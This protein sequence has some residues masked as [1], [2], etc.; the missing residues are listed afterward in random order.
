[1]EIQ[2]LRQK[3]H[4]SASSINSYL[5]CGLQYRFSRIDKLKA[6]FTADV[7]V[8]GSTIHKTIEFVQLNRMAGD[9]TTVT[10][11]HQ[12]FEKHWRERA[13]DNVDIQYGK[14]E[15]FNSLLIQGKKLMEVYIN[16]LPE[17]GYEVLALEEPF[18]LLLDGIDIPIIGV[19]DMV[20]E[21]ESGTIIITDHKTA[22][23]AYSTEEVDKNF[24]LTVYHMA[25][26]K[27]GYDGRDI[28]MKFDC[29]IK[30]KTPRFDQ[31]Y[32]VRSEESEIRAVKKIVSVWEGISKGVFIPNDNSWRCSTCAYKS[33]CD[34]WHQR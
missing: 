6:D 15:S 30:T 26:R 19:M 34:R 13:E 14:G 31:V 22:A 4:L 25:A 17:T 3:P 1:M 10:E 29:L 21:D 11:A 7:L 16:S 12:F 8:Y 33:H 2:E 5:E 27:N 9:R 32:T 28:L 23:R 24:Q 18:E 20:E